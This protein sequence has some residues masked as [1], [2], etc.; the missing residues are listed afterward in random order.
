MN[1]SMFVVRFMTR[2][3]SFEHLFIVMNLDGA[4]IIGIFREFIC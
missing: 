1:V 4:I 2:I 3:L